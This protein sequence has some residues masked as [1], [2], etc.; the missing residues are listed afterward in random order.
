MV[1]P[2]KCLYNTIKLSIETP[3][4]I[5]QSSL[6]VSL[7]PTN[8]GHIGGEY[9]EPEQVLVLIFFPTVGQ[10]GQVQAVHWSQVPSALLNTALLSGF[11]LLQRRSKLTK[12]NDSF[13]TPS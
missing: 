6:L 11:T 1:L 5:K 13:A 10:A 9:I 4:P 2:L 7:S 8:P 12:L 3:L